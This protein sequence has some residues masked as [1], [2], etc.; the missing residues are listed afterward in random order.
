MWHLGLAALQHVGSSGP[1]LETVSPALA[2]GVIFLIFKKIF[3]FYLFLA[4]LGLRCCARAFSSCGEWGLL[5]V[6]VCGL[7]IVVASLVVEHRL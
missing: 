1:G 2:G 6:A 5:L 7:L 3:K 4:A